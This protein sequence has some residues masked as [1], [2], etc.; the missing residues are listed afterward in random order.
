MAPA[1][2][3][4]AAIQAAL[5]YLDQVES[6]I[7][8][9]KV[10]WAE[11]LTGCEARNKY[12]VMAKPLNFDIKNQDDAIKQL[13]PFFKMKENSECC[14]RCCFS[15]YHQ[16][17]VHVTDP[18]GVP[19]FCFYRPFLCTLYCGFATIAPQCLEVMDGM[20]QQMGKVAHYHTCCGGGC[21][22]MIFHITD[23]SSALRFIVEIAICQC[24]PDMCCEEWV[25]EIK[26]ST[27]IVVG[28]IK[29]CW[30]GCNYRGV[31]SKADN[32]EINCTKKTAFTPVDKVLLLGT[33]ILFDYMFFEMR[34]EEGGANYY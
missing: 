2:Q 26:D 11:E 33:V 15:P 13:P 22:P 17:S 7:I 3:T 5:G 18:S 6:M 25:A 12:K 19:V 31:C 21:A 34:E 27:S 14:E 30:P 29:N 20:G 28:N 9:Q 24:G 16:L 8:R 32:F 10:Q 4:G 1:P 23:T